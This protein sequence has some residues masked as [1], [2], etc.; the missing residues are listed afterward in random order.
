M[1]LLARREIKLWTSFGDHIIF[2]DNL[3]LRFKLIFETETWWKADLKQVNTQ[4]KKKK[5]Q[6]TKL[7]IAAFL[8]PTF[9]NTDRK[10]EMLSRA[11][12]YHRNYSPAALN[13]V[14]VFLFPKPHLEGWIYGRPSLGADVAEAFWASPAS[15]SWTNTPH[16]APKFSWWVAMCIIFLVGSGGAAEMMEIMW[17]VTPCSANY[18]RLPG[19]RVQGV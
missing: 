11:L 12:S 5:K 13:A 14:T 17:I 9:R 7:N 4:G 19:A 2:L 18:T 15:L 16:R 8:W 1:K 10:V 3:L 6:K